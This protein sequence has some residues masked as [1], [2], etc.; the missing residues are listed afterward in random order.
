M[1]RTLYIAAAAILT[2]TSGTAA[3]V[4]AAPE[5]P[6]SKYDDF[7]KKSKSEYDSFLND[8]KKDYSDFRSKANDDYA[9]FLSAP[10][11][12]V[13]LNAPK[14]KP[15]DRTLPPVR[16]PKKQQ[17]PRP[18]K[19]PA[20]EIIIPDRNRDP[21]PQPQPIAPVQPRQD[22][23]TSDIPVTIYGTQVT[24]PVSSRFSMPE[25]AASE[26][27]VAKAWTALAGSG[28][29]DATIKALLD[30]RSSYRM[31]DWMYF[32]IIS[33]L[34]ER[35]APA[36]S[37][38]AALLKAFIFSQSG[39]SERMGIVMQ[40]AE[41]LIAM[42]GTTDVI[43]G[44]SYYNVDG[45]N[46]FTFDPDVTRLR[47]TGKDFSGAKPMN[48]VMS[49]LPRLSMDA[50]P[51]RTI[52]CV[53][54]PD[55]KA[56]VNSNLNLMRMFDDYP[57]SGRPNEST[58]KYA[59]YAQTPLSES[60]A[61]QLLPALRKAISGKSEK[62]AAN[63]IID[64]C[65]SIPY[66]YDNEA[67][68]HDRAFFA[69]ETLYYPGGDCEDHAILFVRLIHEL[70]K[71]PVALVYFPG[72]LAAAVQFSTDPGGSYIESDGKRWTICDPTIFYAPIGTCMPTVDRSKA[73][74]IPLTL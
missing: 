10:W 49:Q 11:T 18:D 50:S 35:L 29:L 17:S 45:K 5:T 24:I 41:R 34:V 70:L 20:P 57:A 33:L 46:Y 8:A 23:A 55:I 63:I 61:S 22:E 15:K 12:P 7:L 52:A 59:Y 69:D 13:N 6:G 31:S 9:S 1:K 48:L 14:Q 32:R 43:Y 42:P 54:Y 62:D 16:Q 66:V 44:M 21:E 68:G 60:T 38:E 56:T 40:G 26:S 51:M 37:N 2:L 73:V 36:P 67:W 39:Y 4:S 71:R 25:V 47:I 74:L 30:A 3:P 28:S 58:S 72:H 53:G 27:G 65:E 19:L 64:F